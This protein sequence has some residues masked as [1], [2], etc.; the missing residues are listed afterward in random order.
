MIMVFSNFALYKISLLAR[1]HS[2]GITELNLSYILK[3]KL[4]FFIFARI[5]CYKFEKKW[6]V[7]TYV[8]DYQK[9]IYS[10]Y[11]FMFYTNIFW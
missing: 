6:S 3:N 4:R 10:F 9:Y 2:Y 5:S 7:F 11:L 1:S 8:V